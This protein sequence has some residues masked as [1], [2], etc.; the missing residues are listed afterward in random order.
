MKSQIYYN[1]LRELE[2][3]YVIYM[4]A[5][6]AL[7]CATGTRTYTRANAYALFKETIALA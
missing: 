5:S 1:T 3:L 6:F 7:I 4:R 2:P